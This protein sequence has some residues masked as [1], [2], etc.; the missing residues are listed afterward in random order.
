MR[1]V[2]WRAV[3]FGALFFALQM[4][5]QWA[6]GTS[7]ERFVV[8]DGTVRPAA[9]IINRLTPSLNARAIDLNLSAVGEELTIS[10]GCEGL[11]ALFLLV[12]AFAVAPLSWSA[13]GL[14]LAIGALVVFAANQARIIALF[15]A[16]RFTPVAF[17]RLHDF[18]APLAVVLLISVYF[19]A[20]LTR[21]SGIAARAG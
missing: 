14:G 19:Y 10:N 5:W 18:F 3:V 4:T 17:D 8:H 12:A 2:I 6:R 9:F 21:Y 15:Y 7:L 13:R 11:D 16:Y 1:G 20:W